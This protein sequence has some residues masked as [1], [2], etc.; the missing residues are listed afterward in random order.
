LTIAAFGLIPIKRR[1]KIALGKK[2]EGRVG[3]AS[4]KV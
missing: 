2:E 3:T 4:R 1:G